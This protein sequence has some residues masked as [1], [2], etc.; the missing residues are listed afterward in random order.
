MQSTKGVQS[1]L[2]F[3]KIR[4]GSEPPSQKVLSYHTDYNSIIKYVGHRA[5]F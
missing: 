5:R 3:W 2:K 4:G 1:H